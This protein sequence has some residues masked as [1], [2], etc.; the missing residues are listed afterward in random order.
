MKES[1]G[2]IYKTI[3]L[4]NGKI[5]IGQTIKKESVFKYYLGG[6][7]F[8]K[9]ALKKYGK[10]NFKKEIICKCFSKE[11]LDEKEIYFIK[12]LKPDYNI[13]DG[14]GGISGFTHSE[15]TRRKI[16]E[17]HK[18]KNISEETRKKLSELNKG[19]HLSEETKKKI[20]DSHKGEKHWNFGKHPSEETLKKMRDAK[21]GKHISEET[22]RKMSE[23]NKGKTKSEETCKK[24]S[25]ANKG[26]P[27]SEETLKKVRKKVICVETQESFDSL[28]EA[29]KKYNVA[30]ST[31]C[32]CC[33]GKRK[34]VGGFHWKYYE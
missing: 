5:Y 2:V 22:R 18:E 1:Y 17:A 28:T 31:I 3:N 23:S 14:G 7:S 19:K 10:E 21:K 6:G 34:T 8:F 9:N 15:E 29:G 12:E 24:L 30:N 16:S 13:T 27:P 11:E 33:R 20:G 32:S 4:I 26:K 25:E